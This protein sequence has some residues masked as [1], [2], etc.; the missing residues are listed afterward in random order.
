MKVSGLIRR[1]GEVKKTSK[2]YDLKVDAI[3][4]PS[5]TYAVCINT[6]C[7]T[8]G[9]VKEKYTSFEY[10]NIISIIYGT[11]SEG[12]LDFNIQMIVYPGGGTLINQIIISECLE[13]PNYIFD[14]DEDSFYSIDVSYILNMNDLQTLP[15][16]SGKTVFESIEYFVNTWDLRGEY[17]NR[18]QFFKPISKEKIMDFQEFSNYTN[19]EF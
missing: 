4:N 12:N 13:H 15:E 14:Y 9:E 18:F 19:N 11:V 16:Y 10:C 2:N 17:K 7:E 6:N 3:I 8:T 1:E 5:H